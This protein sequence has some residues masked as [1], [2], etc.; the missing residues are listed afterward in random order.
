MKIITTT[1][2]QLIHIQQS[3]PIIENIC[4]RTNLRNSYIEWISEYN[5]EWFITLTFRYTDI[6][7]REAFSKLTSCVHRFERALYGKHRARKTV[8]QCLSM[9][10]FIERNYKDG[11]H[12]HCLVQP[13]IDLG[14][15]TVTKYIPLLRKI[16]EEIGGSWRQFDCK[17]IATPSDVYRL[18]DYSTKQ[19][20]K[21]NDCVI[22]T[23][24]KKR[25]D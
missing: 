24:F 14:K 20:L 1:N 12:F 7:E 25:T 4:S 9:V 22:L 19:I 15:C 3:N 18:V 16:W 17:N 21:N 10:V 11:F 6:T 23:W 5:F 2:K 8:K 13:P